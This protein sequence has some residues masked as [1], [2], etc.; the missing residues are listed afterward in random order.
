MLRDG[1]T[2]KPKQNSFI[3]RFNRTYR[4]EVLKVYV[5]KFLSEVREITE[6]WM[7]EHNEE[8]PHESLEN[9]TPAEYLAAHQ[10]MENSILTQC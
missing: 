8:Y 10:K 4:D 5:F 7:V 2:G 1:Y 9:Q 3:E 6:N